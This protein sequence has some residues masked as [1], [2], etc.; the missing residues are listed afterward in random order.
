[1]RKRVE[2][3]RMLG[4]E[5]EIQGATST[6]GFGIRNVPIVLFVPSDLRPQTIH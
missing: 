4:C 1:M 2:D 6:R 3:A 5:D